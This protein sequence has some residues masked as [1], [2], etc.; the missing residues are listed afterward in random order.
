MKS[1]RFLAWLGAALL[2]LLAA[3]HAG[4]AIA[5]PA[6]VFAQAPVEVRVP[7]PPRP[8]VGSDG[9]THLAYELH[10]G[11]FYKD[12]GTLTLRRV[13][14]YADDETTPLASFVDAQ[15][16]DLLAHPADVARA[17]V[18]VEGGGQVVLFL[19]LDLP[20]GARPPKVL[21]HQLEFRPPA[22]PEQ[23]VDGVR[24]AVDAAPPI[25][26]GPPLGEGRWLAHEGPGN[27]L[28][29][30]WGSLVAANG[31][32]TIPQRYAVDFFGLDQAGHAVRAA[33]DKLT[34]STDADWAGFGAPVLAVADG[35]VRDA[36]DGQPDNRPMTSPPAPAELTARSLMG[37]FVVLEIAPRVFVSYAHLQPGSLTVKAGDRVKRGAVIG[38]LG[39][40]GA[41]N[42][43]HLHF[44][45]TDAATFEESEGL[46][47][48]IDR[49]DRLG[50]V[51]IS[52]ALDRT[53][54][55]SLGPP[56]ARREQTPLDGD[57]LQFR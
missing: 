18:P 31:R 45:V 46:P 41:A 57:V 29:H 6:Q 19:W 32:V 13:S 54:K 2:G 21:R 5:S 35:V 8:T 51:S 15:V 28:S 9:V 53:A 48:V 16:N 4:G 47:F 40:S 55:V 3:S 43:P 1:C 56:S 50:A 39:Q 14:V 30:H 37:N 25:V 24:T 52:D 10:V 26:I 20:A 11:N 12:T 49:F 44:Q 42:A 34:E 23:L 7:A 27:H 22:G 38:L 36:R 33:L 17:G